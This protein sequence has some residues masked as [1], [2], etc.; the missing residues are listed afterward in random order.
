MLSE[1]KKE[2]NSAVC[3]LVEKA[4]LK[5]GNIVVVGCSSSEILGEKIGTGSQPEVAVIV[6]DEIVAVLKDK[7]IYL[8]CQCCEHLNRALVVEREAAEKFGLE[9]VNAVPQVKAGGSFAT[10]AYKG[11]CDPVVVEFIKADAGLDI[12][13]TLI[14][15]HLKHVAVP[16]R[17]TIKKIGEANLTAARVRPKFVGGNRAVY[18]ENLM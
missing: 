5:S 11:F 6:F 4:K 2:I 15:M 13:D 10:A 18:D 7:G 14:G 1:L 8:A 17:L 3:E 12:G 16:L 9:Q